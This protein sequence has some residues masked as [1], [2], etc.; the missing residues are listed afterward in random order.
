MRSS[1]L[2]MVEIWT[3]L[4][5]SMIHYQGLK[6][7]GAYLY[8]NFP[9]VPPHPTPGFEGL[10]SIPL[11]KLSLSAPTPHPRVWRSWEHTSTQTFL[12]CPHTPSQGLKILGAYLY[13]NFPWVPP[14][15]T[16]GF[17]G[18]GSIPL[19]KLPFSVPTPAPPLLGI[20]HLWD[21]SRV[22]TVVFSSSPLL[23]MQVYRG[24]FI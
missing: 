13:R 7:L 18:L 4:V 1:V 16:P 22:A 20:F 2:N 8:P 17:E 6:V 19:P 21:R 14:H 11:P 15:P 3:I 9:W 12:E 23:T 24:T 10:G 5:L